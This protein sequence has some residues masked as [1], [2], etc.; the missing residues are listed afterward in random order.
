MREAPLIEQARS[1]ATTNRVLID[2]LIEKVNFFFIISYL[3]WLPFI[4]LES[5]NLSHLKL[6]PNFTQGREEFELFILF[7]NS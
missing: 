7:V 5:Q 4:G 2:F 3:D 1:E 6:F